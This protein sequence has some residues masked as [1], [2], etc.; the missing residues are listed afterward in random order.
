[1]RRVDAGTRADGAEE[2]VRGGDELVHDGYEG[3]LGQVVALAAV[4]VKAARESVPALAEAAVAGAT[5]SRVPAARPPARATRPA[6][7][8]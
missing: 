2:R 8:R 1:M 6:G 5:P 7:W 3:Q 4:L